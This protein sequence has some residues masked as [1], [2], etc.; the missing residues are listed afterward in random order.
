M[1]IIA[2]AA[3][4]M[5][6]AAP[7]WADEA[8]KNAANTNEPIMLSEAEMDTVTAGYAISREYAIFRE[9]VT[10]LAGTTTSSTI[11]P[12]QTLLIPD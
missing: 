12:G 6:M 8:A 10:P 9:G 7:T 3:V 5:M 4:L 11:Y 2:T 1:K